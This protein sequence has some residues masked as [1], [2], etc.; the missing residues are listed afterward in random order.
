MKLMLEYE[1]I[2]R[3]RQNLEVNDEMRQLVYE[4]IKMQ[5]APGEVVPEITEKMVVAAFNGDSANTSFEKVKLS[6][7]DSCNLICL[8]RNA[9]Y[10]L[11]DDAEEEILDTSNQPAIESI[12]LI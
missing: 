2:Q 4:Y 8:V 10:G 7:G 5:A 3:V 9:I 12:S 11:F 1:R 6:N